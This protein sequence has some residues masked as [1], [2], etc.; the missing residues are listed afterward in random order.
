MKKTI[1]LLFVSTLIGLSIFVSCSSDKEDDPGTPPEIPPVESFIMD[2]SDFNE[3]N[4]SNRQESQA[5]WGVAAF[6]VGIWNV[7]TAVTLAVP[8]ASFAN[9]VDSEPIYDS[10]LEAFIWT[11]DYDFVGRT[12]SSELRGRVDGS[13][14]LWE[15]YISQENG[16]Q[17][18]LWFS[19]QSQ[20]DGMGGAWTLNNSPENPGAFLEIDWSKESD[21]VG[22]IRYTNISGESGDGSYIE[23]GRIESSEYDTYYTINNTET[24][25]LVEIEW[26]SVTK[27]GRIKDP[28]FFEDEDYRCWDDQFEDTD[29]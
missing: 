3:T 27:I 26:N 23:Y 12:Y 19:G 6:K 22:Q 18:F 13:V 9:S 29:C 15:M 11:F 2:F 28:G 8:V 10:E 4:V 24:D 21:E 17:D 25:N 20:L 5:H 1:S 16:F 14:V 7:I